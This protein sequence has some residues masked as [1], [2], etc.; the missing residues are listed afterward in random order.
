MAY[1][2]PDSFVELRRRLGQELDPMGSEET[3]INKVIGFAE[4]MTDRVTPENREERLLQEMWSLATG[5]EK[6]TLAKV[7]VRLVQE[8]REKH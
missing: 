4:E 7:L 1:D 2:T 8:T 6:K 5:E 3:A